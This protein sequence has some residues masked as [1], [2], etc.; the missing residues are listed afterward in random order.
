M[1]ALIYTESMF[2]NEQIVHIFFYISLLLI[3]HILP[4]A[5][6]RIP[7]LPIILFLS[8]FGRILLPDYYLPFN[9]IL[10]LTFFKI[11]TL[12]LVFH[13]AMLVSGP[14][15]KFILRSFFTLGFFLIFVFL[16]S[17]LIINAFY[18]SAKSPF[19]FAFQIMLIGS[20]PSVLNMLD[21]YNFTDKNAPIRIHYLKASL[22]KLLI[23]IALFAI[24]VLTSSTFLLEEVTFGLILAICSYFL[25]RYLHNYKHVTAYYVLLLLGFVFALPSNNSSLLV[26]IICGLSLGTLFAKDSEIVQE[27]KASSDIFIRTLFCSMIYFLAYL[28]PLRFSAFSYTLVISLTLIVFFISLFFK[29][30]EAGSSILARVSTL[31]PSSFLSILL[32]Y[33]FADYGFIA[34]DRFVLLL[35]IFTLILLVSSLIQFVYSLIAIGRRDEHT[36]DDDFSA[37][38][39]LENDRVVADY[40]QKFKLLF[41]EVIKGTLH[42]GYQQEFSRL[43]EQQDLVVKN[44]NELTERLK[45]EA[46]NIHSGDDVQFKSRL[47]ERVRESRG[48]LAEEY[49]ARLNINQHVQSFTVFEELPTNFERLAGEL[50]TYPSYYK[51][52]QSFVIDGHE[53]DKLYTKV[54]KFLKRIKRSIYRFFNP[55]FQFMQHIQ[56]PVI[57]GYHFYELFGNLQENLLN[58][59]GYQTFILHRKANNLYAIADKELIKLFDFIDSENDLTTFLDRFNL[60]LASAIKVVQDEQQ[61]IEMDFASFDDANASLIEKKYLTFAKKSMNDAML[62]GTFQLPARKRNPSRLIEQYEES[63]LYSEDLFSNWENY[64]HGFL[65]QYQI[66]I[67]TQLIQ[68]SLRKIINHHVGSFSELVDDKISQVISELRVEFSKKPKADIPYSTVRKKMLYQ[69]KIILLNQVEALKNDKQV[70]KFL[71]KMFIDVHRAVLD[72]PRFYKVART[73]EISIKPNQFPSEI[74]LYHVP[75]QNVLKTLIEIE[76]NKNLSIVSAQIS[77][78]L[79]NLIK[80]IEELIELFNESDD[81]LSNERMGE[82]FKTCLEKLDEVDSSVDAISKG[83][84]HTIIREIVASLNKVKEIVDNNMDGYFHESSKKERRIKTDLEQLLESSFDRIKQPILAFSLRLKN[85]VLS[86][87]KRESTEVKKAQNNVFSPVLVESLERIEALPFMYRKVMTTDSIDILDYFVA[88]KIGLQ[89]LI[90]SITRWQAEPHYAIALHGEMGT[91]KTTLINILLKYH[92]KDVAYSRI[93]I[94]Y[95][96]STEELLCKQICKQLNLQCE[97]FNFN[98]LRQQVVELKSK[99]VVIV[100]S[101]QHLIRKSM[102][103]FQL[104]LTFLNFVQDTR[105]QICWVCTCSEFGW[106]Y[107]EGTRSISDYFAVHFKLDYSSSDEIRRVIEVRNSTSGFNFQFLDLHERT[108]FIHKFLQRRFKFRDRTKEIYFSKLAKLANGNLHKAIYIWLNSLEL[109]EDQTFLVHKPERI[110]FPYLKK[111]DNKKMILLASILETGSIAAESASHLL[112]ES[113]QTTSAILDELY[114]HEL[115]HRKEVEQ[116]VYYAIRKLAATEVVLELKSR[117]ICV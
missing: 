32:I 21:L 89:S 99:R 10:N 98:E 56:L 113:I 112:H 81:A 84:R 66:E 78:G 9:D 7:L 11:V 76:I 63:R 104:M 40:L 49:Q 67:E 69:L 106:L 16:F 26:F 73:Q 71:D 41:Y 94:G 100:E 45:V 95:S 77:V 28:L 14:T 36:L 46:V 51:Y 35:E 29:G 53:S 96:I 68:G 58:Q 60:E 62:F 33:Y 74:E 102:N 3:V 88:H 103:G 37:N 83:V 48:R 52:Q 65:G 8:I 12:L 101:I 70:S 93:K 82:F 64:I 4:S 54:V 87:Y 90:E 86:R 44:F 92:L 50:T 30:K 111:V 17:Y 117:G 1:A 79:E 13:Y 91:G 5:K 57:M 107:L 97:S 6:W 42:A 108:S 27:L 85:A 72:V 23:I 43:Q 114:L 55:S 47:K 15:G 116:N 34:Q 19:E 61:I 110:H 109:N 39:I 115:L 80:G 22:S 20:V 25:I 105:Q 38:S 2:L 59:I 75:F 18:P 31:L 24:S